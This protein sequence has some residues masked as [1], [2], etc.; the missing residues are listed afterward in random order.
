MANETLIK[1]AGFASG[2][3]Q[4]GGF[5]N[6]QSAYVQGMNVPM[7]EIGRRALQEAAYKRKQDEV[8]LKN[9]VNKLEDI[10]LGKVE[11]SMRP[12]VTQFL[13]DNKNDYA[14]AA[15]LAADLDADDPRYMEAVSEMNKINSKFKALSKNLD[16]FKEKRAQFYD[17]VKNNT[18]SKGANVDALTSLFKNNEYD[19]EIDEYGNLS[20]DNEGDLVPLT[21]FD[22]DTDYNYFLTNNE[23]FNTLMTLNEKA[24]T[25]ATKI[26]GGLEQ[27]YRYQLNGLFN[28][29]GR[30]DLMSMVY[31]TVISNVPLKD[32]ED[33]DA[34]L[35]DIE[36]EGEL[37]TWLSNTYLDTFKTVAA[38][39][40]KQKEIQNAPKES[41]AQRRARQAAEQAMK[42]YRE[43]ASSPVA[44][45]SVQGRG[46]KSIVFIAD[47]KGVVKPRPVRNGSL[48]P[49]VV[50][51]KETD[52]QD[53]LTK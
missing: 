1:G 16:L 35:L 24:N 30:E 39:A 17:D 11:D 47:D 50:I 19:I 7:S 21:D 38:Q 31:D 10:E 9:Y 45:A 49:T 51:Y 8:E 40:A 13:V 18:I 53:W 36:R 4:T 14:E 23:G 41:V 32:R 12:E 33:F 34:G 48:D 20:I 37:R 15:R 42:R 27:N 28:T 3:S 46:G 6:L 26:S 43:I 29:M 25:G 44:G 2:G 5:V 22:E 52:A